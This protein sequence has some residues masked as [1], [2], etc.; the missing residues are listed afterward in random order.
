[1]PLREETVPIHEIEIAIDARYQLAKA[2]LQPEGLE[3]RINRNDAGSS[4]MVPRLEIHSMVV[5]ELAK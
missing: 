1:V 2:V 5:L 3:L 4:V